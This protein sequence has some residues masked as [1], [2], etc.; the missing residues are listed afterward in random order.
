MNVSPEFSLPL[1]L[2]APYFVAAVVFYIVSM[3]FLFFV[4]PD[5]GLRDFRLIGWVHLYMIGFVMMVIIGAM[6]QLSVVVGEAHHRYPKVF[7]WIWPLLALGT[8]VLLAGFYIDAKMLPFGGGIILGGLGLFA[9]NLFVTLRRSRRRTSVTL[10]M[11]WSTLFL[12]VGLGIG[13][14]MA[15]GYAG[16]VESDPAQW[17]MGHIFSVFGGYV[18]LNIMGVSTVLLP[19]FG[20]CNRPSD[21]DHTI[22]FYTMVVSVSVM[23]VASALQIVWLEKVALLFG[24]GSVIYYMV[25]VYRIFTS[26]KRGYSDIWERSAAVAFIALNV[27]MGL[28]IYGIIVGSEKAILLSFWF[29]TAGFLGFLITAHLYK[30]VPFLVWF[31]RYAP[32]LDEREVPMLHQ[33]LPARW[34]NIQWGL[35][36]SGLVAIAIAIGLA[37]TVLWKIGAL[38]L[39]GSG[40]VLLAI[41]VK[42]LRDKL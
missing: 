42:I 39:I 25:Q 10:S 28:G 8:A 22:S 14:L 38:F 15:L 24:I 35:G 37:N 31:E 4:Q 26:K 5:I 17:R 23:I 30:I 6:G 3:S 33:L 9:F 13:V 12:S 2:I 34:A 7:G 16:V 29:L 1:R 18:M 36:V 21:R 19:M 41:L 27:S 20:A 11:Q 32:Y 40:V